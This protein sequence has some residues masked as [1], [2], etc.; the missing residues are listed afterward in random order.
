M[1][2]SAG[3]P[4]FSRHWPLVRPHLSRLLMVGLVV[5]VELCSGCRRTET[6]TRERACSYSV[7]TPPAGAPPAPTCPRMTPPPPMIRIGHSAGRP[8]ERVTGPAR[9]DM[10]IVCVLFHSIPSIPSIPSRYFLEAINRP[11]EQDG[12]IWD[13]VGSGSEIRSQTE[14]TIPAILFLDPLN[15]ISA[16]TVRYGDSDCFSLR[17]QPPPVTE[18]G[19]GRRDWEGQGG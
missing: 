11:S 6:T 2:S 10:P 8:H 13:T 3:T 9:G 4:S 17:A 18:A 12:G 1:G 15:G 16:G 5:G 14:R 7:S 19:R